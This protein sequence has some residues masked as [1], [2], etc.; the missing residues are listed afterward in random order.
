ME[1]ANSAICPALLWLLGKAAQI[2]LH[3]V[4]T[5]FS[6]GDGLT[7]LLVNWASWLGWSPWRK[8][9][10]LVPAGHLC[11]RTECFWLSARVTWLRYLPGQGLLSPCCCCV[12]RQGAAACLPS[13]QHPL[14]YELRLKTARSGMSVSVKHLKR[15]WLL[16]PALLCC[17]QCLHQTAAPC[18]V[19]SPHELYRQDFIGKDMLIV[20]NNSFSEN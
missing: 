1:T 5:R 16:I 17:W 19:A 14:R 2:Y 8:G 7:P 12:L 6:V 20:I 3:L 4:L 9:L 18:R 11:P 13:A 15:T 10:Q